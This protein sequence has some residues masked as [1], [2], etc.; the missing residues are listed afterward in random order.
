MAAQLWVPHGP[1]HPGRPPCSCAGADGDEVSALSHPPT[2]ALRTAVRSA[3]HLVPEPGRR[4]SPSPRSHSSHR[5]P[6]FHSGCRPLC[7]CATRRRLASGPCSPRRC[8][9]CTPALTTRGARK[10]S[11]TEACLPSGAQEPQANAPRGAPAPAD[12]SETD[13]LSAPEVPVVPRKCPQRPGSSGSAPE[14]PIGPR[15]GPVAMTTWIKHLRWF[16]QDRISGGT[17]HSHVPVSGSASR[18]TRRDR[19]GPLETE[20]EITP[21]RLTSLQ[22][23]HKCCGCLLTQSGGPRW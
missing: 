1:G 15:A 16:P 13:L 7:A 17:A 18:D 3:D 21:N 11:S 12:S 10:P 2:A 5:R 6:R 23:C 4:G 8:P 19:R 22:K 9:P 14:V 20:R